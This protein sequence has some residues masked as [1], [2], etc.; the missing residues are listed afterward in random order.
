M[1]KKIILW[2][3]DLST[4]IAWQDFQHQEFLK[5]TNDLFD[6]F[7]TK[8]GQLELD[9]AVAGLQQY[10]RDHFRIEERYMNLFDYP[11]RELHKEQHQ[12]FRNFTK[13]LSVLE[14]HNTVEGARLCNMLNQWFTEHIKGS[15]LALGRFLQE[16]GQR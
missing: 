9:K 8:K 11:E 10:A 3:P 1:E 4:D 12:T 5:F 6:D 15:D 14:R 16:Q 7:Y 2:T 13:Q